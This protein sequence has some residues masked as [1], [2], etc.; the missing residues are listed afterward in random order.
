MAF[1]PVW[2]LGAVAGAYGPHVLWQPLW[3]SMALA[4]A[5]LWRMAVERGRLPQPPRIVRWMLAGAAMAAVV[6]T[7]GRT[8]ALDAGTEL[9]CLAAGLKV[10][11]ARSR[12]DMVLVVLVAYV[13]AATH[14]LFAQHLAAAVYMLA[15]VVLSTAA[16]GSMTARRPWRED[17]RVGVLV[18]LQALPLALVAFVA[19]PRLSAGVVGLPVGRAPQGVTGL[20][21]TVQPGSIGRLAQS[22][23]VALRVAMDGEIPPRTDWYWRA[24]VLD[25]VDAGGVW[26]QRRSPALWQDAPAARWQ[27]RITLEPHQLPWLIALDV[28]VAAPPGARLDQWGRVRWPRPVRDRIVYG[29]QSSSAPPPWDGDPAWTSLPSG[30]A[31]R[32]RRLVATWQGGPEAVAKAA[33]AF[34]A[35]GGFR[36]TL[37]PVAAAGDPVDG[38]VLG[39][40]EGFCEHYAAALAVML[41][42]ARIPARVV[43][44]YL[45]GEVNAVTGHITVRQSDAHA[46]VEAVLD[47]VYGWQ[48]LD[49]TLAVAPERARHGLAEGVGAVAPRMESWGGHWLRTLWD[50]ADH[51]WSHWV[52]D[53]TAERQRRLA[54]ALGKRLPVVA[55]ALVLILGMYSAWRWRRRPCP[56]ELAAAYADVRRW[57]GRQGMHCP[58]WEGPRSLRRRV[59]AELPAAASWVGE[60]LGRYEVLRYGGAADAAAAAQLRREIRRLTRRSL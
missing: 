7:H 46:W 26:R 44:G 28:P 60:L 40:R 49:P 48:R 37:D 32:T 35:H 24:V 43:A 11:E 57:L 2:I 30:L 21:E 27:G 12:R 36:Y 23:E 42:A 4:A 16:L 58:A 5:L 54:A 18:V 39:T 51:T 47:P 1:A 34:F 31:P 38:F 22:S 17:L 56:D 59:E 41:R 45:G 9:L 15:S 10:L 25:S 3:V 14:V 19:M 52:L 20:A 29:W 50:A 13:L 53:F 33:L 8:F 55:A 6:A